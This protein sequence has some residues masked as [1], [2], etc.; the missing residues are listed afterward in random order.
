MKRLSRHR[1][2]LALIAVL[3]PLAALF[4]Y[5]ALRSGP[6]APIP[7]TTTVVTSQSIVPSLFG[8]GTVEA[9]YTF[10]IGPTAAGRVR[11]VNVNVG[12]FV[13]AGQLL[14]EMDPVDLDERISAQ[15]AALEHAQ[16]EMQAAGARIG[17]AS[18]RKTFA[19]AQARRYD[20]LFAKQVVSAEAVEAKQ[21]ELRVAQ[22]NLLAAEAGLD[23]ARREADRISADREGLI[24][25]RANL[26][27]MSMV[28]GLV[29][30]RSAEPGSTV[31]AGQ[32]VVEVIHPAHL[33]VHVRFD[34]L[35]SAGLRAGLPAEIVLRSAAGGAMTGQ[36]LR[37]EP[38]ADAVTEEALAKVIFDPPL[39]TL[40]PIGE[41]AEVSVALPALPQAPT[42][43]NAAIRRIGGDLGVWV[44]S[45]DGLRFAPIRMGA[46]DLDG[47]VQIL[48]GV[49]PGENVVVYSQRALDAHS[50]IK[51]VDRLPGVAP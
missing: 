20:Q 5:A 9:R 2:A 36:V 38:L 47:Q 43:P 21:Q 29:I 3:A 34:Q 37:V 26:R 10:Q 42:A 27:L 28:D 50:R 49:Q 12:D 45:A 39:A 14:G 25:Q 4:A 18:A 19:E 35:G 15:A 6:L 48:E 13:R 22:A 40:P 1:R 23:A 17:D 30:K 44:V 33:W 11:Q 41:L 51:I 32:S 46:H 8:I 31:I 16:A 7:V 24:R